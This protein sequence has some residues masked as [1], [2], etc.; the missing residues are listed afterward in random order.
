MQ[1]DQVIMET[2]KGNSSKSDVSKRAAMQ[3]A[4]DAIIKICGNTSILINQLVPSNF[5][6]YWD[7]LTP[8]MK[9]K[10]QSPSPE[11]QKIKDELF[12]LVVTRDNV[13]EAMWY[14]YTGILLT[15][16]VQL[17]IT[18]R[19]CVSNSKT[20]EQNYK[21]FLEVEEKNKAKQSKIESTTYTMTG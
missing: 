9:E 20:M 19:G 17:K 12:N 1:K 3:D 18:S 10:Y 13:G 15:S 16:I 7:I 6:Q 21:K 14:L 11:T 4:A 8:L 5:V 2:A